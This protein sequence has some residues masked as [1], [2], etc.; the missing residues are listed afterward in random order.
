MDACDVMTTAVLTIQPST[1][2]EQIAELMTKRRV[3]GLPVVDADGRLLGIVTEGD[4]YR[5]ADL[6]TE[7]RGRGLLEMLLPAQPAAKEYVE[8]RGTVAS[9]VMTSEVIAA[10]PDTTLRQIAD[11][12]ETKGF[13]RVPVLENGRLVGIVSRADLVRALAS[14]KVGGVPAKLD[15]RQIRDLVLSEF[16]RLPFGLRSEGS[17]IVTDGVVHLWGFV[18][19]DDEKN[20]LRMAASGVPGV[21]SVEDHTRRF[22]AAFGIDAAPKSKVTVVER[23]P[24]S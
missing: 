7:R 24:N 10:A 11:L 6:G 18:P 16:R 13:R 3:S 5:R 2:I 22:I 1:S 4:L 14:R 21:K 9:E 15:D 23:D 8:A 19:S 12:F 17:V 20:A